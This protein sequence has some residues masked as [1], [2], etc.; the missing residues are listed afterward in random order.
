MQAIN[1]E[2]YWDEWQAIP[3][4]DNGRLAGSISILIGKAHGFIWVNATVDLNAV[5][6]LEQRTD[7]LMAEAGWTQVRRAA[8]YNAPGLY[9]VKAWYNRDCA[10]FE[11]IQE[12][13]NQSTTILTRKAGT[14]LIKSEPEARAFCCYC[15]L[16]WLQEQKDDTNG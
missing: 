10:G 5:A 14:I 15:V 16:R 11:S 12:W 3:R 2:K 9:W 8:H 4:E 1:C 6:L 7:E 13:E